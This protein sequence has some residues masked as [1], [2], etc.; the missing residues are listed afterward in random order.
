MTE[1]IKRKVRQTFIVRKNPMLYFLIM[2]LLL[3]VIICSFQS[4]A[5][6]ALGPLTTI[7]TTTWP[8]DD[9]DITKAETYYTKLEAELQKKINNM[10][11][12]QRNYDEYN[13]SIDEIGHDLQ[14][15]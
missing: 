9:E 10:Q 4:F 2:V 6:T 7:T 3:V 13:F 12:S 1:K 5:I 11:N 15:C 8:A 14:W